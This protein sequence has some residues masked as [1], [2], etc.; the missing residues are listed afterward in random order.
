MTNTI[1]QTEASELKNLAR[2]RGR[3]TLLGFGAEIPFDVLDE[4]AVAVE[5][6]GVFEE[7]EVSV[8]PPEEDLGQGSFVRPVV[9][10]VSHA[11]W[12]DRAGTYP[13]PERA[14][15]ISSTSHM[16]GPT[17]NPWIPILGRKGQEVK[18]RDKR[19]KRG[20]T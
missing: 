5:P 19:K 11:G 4:I 2:R 13:T 10:H 1:H 18:D 7:G 20:R 8:G 12:R 9:Y 15:W 6:V 14:C 17:A 3:R 16:S